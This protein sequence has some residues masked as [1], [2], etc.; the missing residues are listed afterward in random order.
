MA[1]EKGI[2]LSVV[3]KDLNIGI[4][5]IVE[6]LTRNGIAIEKKPTAKIN[7]EAYNLLQKEFA[8]D[9]QIKEV[10]QEITKEKFRKENIV[11]EAKQPAAAK[12]KAETEEEITEAPAAE[13]AKP[14]EIEAA[15][16]AEVAQHEMLKEQIPPA[17][18][19]QKEIPYRTER[20]KLTG[21]TILG[22]I[23]LPEPPKKKPVAS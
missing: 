3:V 16:S 4:D 1:E 18:E 15:P 13:V 19:E 12:K 22:K 7:S 21:P 9:K 14:E 17:G 8:Q 10:A 5:H 11:I 6:F 23:D 20:E 2:R